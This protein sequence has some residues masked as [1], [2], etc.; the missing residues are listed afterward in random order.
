MARTSDPGLTTV[1]QNGYEIGSTACRRLIERIESKEM[2][3]CTT[4]VIE[5][6]LIKRNTT[7]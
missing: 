6:R 1:E 4:T 7:K 2:L 3:P 5:T